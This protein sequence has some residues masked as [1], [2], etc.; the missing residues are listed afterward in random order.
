[1]CT[2]LL[3]DWRDILS[4]Y[5]HAIGRSLSYVSDADSLGR[6]LLGNSC[7]IRLLLKESPSLVRFLLQVL[8]VGDQLHGVH[9][10]V[11]VEEHASDLSGGLAILL[12]DHSVDAVTDLLTSL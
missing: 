11:V 5:F 10:T 4:I 3:T 1:M 12:L 7:A 9:N 8:N 2:Y 6:L